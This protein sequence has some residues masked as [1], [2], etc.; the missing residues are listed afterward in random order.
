MA[1]NLD[2]ILPELRS[3]WRLL[4]KFS[5]NRWNLPFIR[6]ATRLFFASKKPADII[7]E[8]V[9][10]AGPDGSSLALRI[11]KPL[12]PVQPVPVLLW[13]HGGG[14]IMGRP[15][16]DDSSSCGFVH[17]LGIAVVSVDYRLTPEHPFPT[18]LEDCYTALK[19][20]FDHAKS[21]GIDPTRIAIGG[22]SA[23]GGLAACL[24]QLAMNRVEIRPVFQLLIYPMLDDRTVLQRDFPDQ[25]LYTWTNNSN[26]FGWESYLKTECGQVNPPP[27]AIAARRESLCGLP[28][29][30]IGV[31]TL[32]LFYREDLSYAEKLRDCGVDCELVVVPGAFHGFDAGPYDSPAIRDFRQSQ[33]N[34]L[35]KHLKLTEA[36]TH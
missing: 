4:P 3:I 32:D 6:F 25:R 22:A 29:A 35:R 31:G 12:S 23:G 10:V 16:M 36:M 13:I 15:E 28:P 27:F 20:T 11:Y 34:A 5:Y 2:P 17:D 7:R 9:R 26:R 30:W 14:Y 24:A 33:M 8:D 21:L 1:T 18:P 19:W